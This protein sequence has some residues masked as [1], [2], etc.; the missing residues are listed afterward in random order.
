MPNIPEE[1]IDRAIERKVVTRRQQIEAIDNRIK[2]DHFLRD[3]KRTSGRS[4]TFIH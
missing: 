2:F 1:L 3:T 4:D